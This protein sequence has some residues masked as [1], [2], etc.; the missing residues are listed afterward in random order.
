MKTGIEMI[1]DERLR[2]IEDEG[3]DNSHDDDHTACELVCAAIC[4]AAPEPIFFQRDDYATIYFVDPWPED[5][6]ADCDKRHRTSRGKLIPG[7]NLSREKRMRDLAKAG[8]LIAAEI[9][10]LQRLRK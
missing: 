2:Q 9:D 5:W 4:Y 7:E 1:T 10:R 3:F 6:D 8:A